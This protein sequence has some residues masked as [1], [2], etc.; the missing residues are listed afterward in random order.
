M[1]LI[2]LALNAHPRWPLVIAANRDEFHAR[3]SDALGPWTD[4]PGVIGGRDR[5]AGGSWLA[6]RGNRLAAV[7]NVR[8]M[9][10]SPADAPSRGWLVRDFVAG[11]M[12][13]EAFLDS[14]RE[15]AQA[16]A[17]FN[18]ILVD[19]DAIHFASN[20]PDWSATPLSIGIH[21]VSNASL[22]TP[23][24]KSERLRE[25]LRTWCRSGVDDSA[26]LFR[27][28]A[29]ETPVADAQLPDTGLPIERERLLAPA[30]I[31]HPMYGTR[32]STVVVRNGK[33]AWRVIE[34]RFGPNGA[35]ERYSAY[36]NG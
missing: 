18:L 21:V 10:T 32:A 17:G 15:H 30:F 24:P 5:V 8:R 20:W 22:D 7:T 25:A 6:L 29:D 35:D 11:R 13:I 1:C 3:D 27:A 12:S 34:R 23:W 16:Y 14:I 19:G 31:R 26:P 9:T 33:G 2:G 4:V 28:L 36:P